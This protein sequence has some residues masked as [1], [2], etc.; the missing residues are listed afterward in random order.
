L[1]HGPPRGMGERPQCV[2][3]RHRL[4][5]NAI[6]KSCNPVAAAIWP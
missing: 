5:M 3:D 1:Q 4:S 6:K 2:I